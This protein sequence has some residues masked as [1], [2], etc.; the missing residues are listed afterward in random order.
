MKYYDYL[1]EFIFAEDTPQKSDVIFIPGSRYGELAVEAARLYREGMAPLIIPSGKYSVLGGR[2][3]GALS[4]AAYAGRV[5]STESEFFAEVMQ[6]NGVPGTAIW[7]EREASFTYENAILSRR[8]LEE[9]GRYPKKGGFKAILVCQAYH[10]R[11]C[12]LYYSYVFPDVRF[13]VCPV[14]TRD[15]SRDNWY[16]EPAKIDVVLGEVERCG[17]QFHEI[18]K[19][20]DKVWR[21][22]K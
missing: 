2:F 8:L 11:R 14:V 13:F 6:E 18:L 20:T 4:P 15:I 16:Q 7:Q 3:E 10:A 1:T 22:R 12:L 19:G 9:K 5:Y 17:S 21:E